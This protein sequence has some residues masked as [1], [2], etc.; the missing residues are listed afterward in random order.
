MVTVLNWITLIIESV[1]G[2]II[3]GSMIKYCVQVLRTPDNGSF[4]DEEDIG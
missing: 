3:F 1:T 4:Y 2:L